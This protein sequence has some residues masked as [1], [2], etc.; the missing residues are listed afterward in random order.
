MTNLSNMVLVPLWLRLLTELARWH[1]M[2]LFFSGE[3]GLMQ[4]YEKNLLCAPIQPKAPNNQ[5]T[6][7]QY[8]Q[9]NTAKH[10]TKTS[11]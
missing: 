7:F 3:T 6:T 4:R 9:H 2:T 1:L 11:A 10:A 5:W 8:Q